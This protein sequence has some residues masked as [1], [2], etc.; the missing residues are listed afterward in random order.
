MFQQSPLYVYGSTI[1][2]N[3]SPVN[4]LAYVLKRFIPVYIFYHKIQRGT[5]QTNMGSYSRRSN[6]EREV[7]EAYN[8]PQSLWNDFLSVNRNG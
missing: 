5:H 2:G 8:Y 6:T 1:L 3:E 7:C 4:Y